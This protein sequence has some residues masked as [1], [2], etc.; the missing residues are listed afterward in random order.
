MEMRFESGGAFLAGLALCGCAVVG[1]LYDRQMADA[2]HQACYDF[3]RAQDWTFAEGQAPQCFA[4]A[5][6]REVDGRL[7]RSAWTGGP[8][9]P[10]RT[11]LAV[12]NGAER[13]CSGERGPIDPN[14]PPD[15]PTM[16]T[17][18][19]VTGSSDGAGA[20]RLETWD[21]IGR[22]NMGEGHRDV[23]WQ[24]GFAG[25]TFALADIGSVLVN[26]GGARIRVTEGAL[27]PTQLCFKSY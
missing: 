25:R 21:R 9:T 3:T 13:R 6:E 19:T 5:E 27:A 23:A 22:P 17:H 20:M 18:L 1:P 15:R 14:T 4:I 8:V 10:G 26:P 7:V 2:R 11:L 12:Y 24:A 16:F